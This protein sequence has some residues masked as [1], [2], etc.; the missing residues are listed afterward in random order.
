MSDKFSELAEMLSI[1]AQEQEVHNVHNEKAMDKWWDNLS[2][3]E[4]E[5]AFYSVAKRINQARVQGKSYR[6]TLYDT[7]KFGANMYTTGIDCGFIEMHNSY[8]VEDDYRDVNRVEL[9]D[10]AGRAY[11]NM[12]VSSVSAELQDAD[13]TLKIFVSTDEEIPLSEEEFD[14]DE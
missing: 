5:K 4:K 10:D 8:E 6:S 13:R 7:F 14:I 11:V 3:S 12:S 2:Q 1:M 9:I